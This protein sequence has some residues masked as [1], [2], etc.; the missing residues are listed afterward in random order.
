MVDAVLGSPNLHVVDQERGDLRPK[1]VVRHPKLR[2]PNDDRVANGRA[3]AVDAFAEVEAVKALAV[4]F[5]VIKTHERKR[6]NIDLPSR[7]VRLLDRQ[8]QFERAGLRRLEAEAVAIILA[9]YIAR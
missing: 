9:G 5:V 3:D 7:T 6:A 8:R 1:G 4:G 2:E